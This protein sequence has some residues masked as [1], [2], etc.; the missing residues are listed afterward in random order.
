MLHLVASLIWIVKT[1][2]LA[3]QLKDFAHIKKI[4]NVVDITVEGTGSE[5]PDGV[6]SKRYSLEGTLI[7]LMIWLTSK[8]N[9]RDLR[10]R[11][12]GL[13]RRGC[14]CRQEASTKGSLVK[15]LHQWLRRRTEGRQYRGDARTVIKR[16][17]GWLS[18]K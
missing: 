8:Q 11:R 10:R 2:A 6:V 3:I 4:V 16:L 18:A 17:H 7:P 5:T 14:S 15:A 9:A 13:M 12:R 1:D